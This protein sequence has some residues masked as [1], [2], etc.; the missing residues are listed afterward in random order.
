MNEADTGAAS[1]TPDK[2]AL[3]QMFR[4]F[5]DPEYVISDD[6]TLRPYECDGLSVYCQQPMLVVLP[7][8]VEQ[9]QQV[10]RICHQ[11]GVPELRPIPPTTSP[12]TSTGRPPPTT[13][14][15]PPSAVWIP[16]YNFV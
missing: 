9:A 15:R 12:S 7:E 10:L 1:P 8:T 16:S 13:H 4:R 11:H 5:I 3:A 14:S 6:E 2:A